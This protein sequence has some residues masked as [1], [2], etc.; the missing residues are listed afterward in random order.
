[1]LFFAWNVAQSNCKT[2]RSDK[3]RPSDTF[4][5]KLMNGACALMIK[6]SIFSV[7]AEFD[8]RDTFQAVLC[9]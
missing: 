3:P 4:T 7:M 8:C 9:L 5:F 6:H 1:M 2:K